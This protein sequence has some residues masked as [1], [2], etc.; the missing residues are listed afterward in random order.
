MNPR[1]LIL[2]EPNRATQEKHRRNV[3]WQITLPLVV[4]IIIGVALAILVSIPGDS[5]LTSRWSSISIVFMAIPLLFIGIIGLALLILLAYGLARLLHIIPPYARL[6]Q[7]YM[8]FLGARIK[9]IA[10]KLAKPIMDI[11]VFLAAVNKML[12]WVFKFK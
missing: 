4:T 9:D 3:L 8:D 2:P 5:A 12:G 10:N 11:N 6:L 7:N 1:Q